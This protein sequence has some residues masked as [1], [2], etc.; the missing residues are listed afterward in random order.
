MK[1]NPR[2]VISYTLYDANRD[3]HDFEVDYMAGFLL[4]LRA[5]N[6]H[7]PEWY[8]RLHADRSLRADEAAPAAAAASS[9]S[10]EPPA[11]T[12]AVED[13]L[14]RI[15]TLHDRRTT[16]WE[17]SDEAKNT[18][19]GASIREL[20]QIVTSRPGEFGVDVIW[21]EYTAPAS[22]ILWRFHPIYDE[23]VEHLLIRDIDSLLTPLDAQ[24]AATW[25]QSKH[26]ALCYVEYLMGQLSAGGGAAFKTAAIWKGYPHV[27][28]LNQEKV[29]A[30]VQPSAR[31]YRPL[32]DTFDP[33]E[34]IPTICCAAL[35]TD[36]RVCS[37]DVWTRD[38]H[39]A[40]FVCVWKARKRWFQW[41]VETCTGLSDGTLDDHDPRH[42]LDLS[43][44][45]L[46]RVDGA[47]GE[48][49]EDEASHCPHR[50]V[51][52]WILS[53]WC[54][55]FYE[56]QQVMVVW[57]RMNNDGA[58]YRLLL[59]IR[60][61]LA[62]GET[63]LH[64]VLPGRFHTAHASELLLGHVSCPAAEKAGQKNEPMMHWVR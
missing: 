49:K 3:T 55:E 22:A 40:L 15:G 10:S 19:L 50:A 16:T 59:P 58:Y 31:R 47:T 62:H 63:A 17:R 29:L 26:L 13:V 5:R 8:I 42:R 51:D 20:F 43:Y 48:A 23:S 45:E 53:T 33:E 7:F 39:E 38:E 4:N 64:R 27:F 56:T 54:L 34:P 37:Q 2:Q 6:E 1:P 14:Q 44:V 18:Q 41:H 57:C 25:M 28:K 21:C 60:A 9:A 35:P 52:E 30:A 46:P 61:Y 11:P 36:T 12:E 24:I 32:P